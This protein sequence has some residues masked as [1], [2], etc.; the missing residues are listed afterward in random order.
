MFS[1]SSTISLIVGLVALS[2]EAY[3]NP[4]NHYDAY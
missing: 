4:A 2:G 3:G 1:N